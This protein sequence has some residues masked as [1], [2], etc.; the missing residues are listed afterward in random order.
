MPR[1]DYEA[2]PD[3]PTANSLV[4]AASVVVVDDAGRILVR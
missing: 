1:S 3:A 2:A 4:P